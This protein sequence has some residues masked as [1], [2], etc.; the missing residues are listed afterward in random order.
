MDMVSCFIHKNPKFIVT[1]LIIFNLNY[2]GST[3]SQITGVWVI[4]S[5]IVGHCQDIFLWRDCGECPI[6]AKI[7]FCGGNFY[8]VLNIDDLHSKPI[9]LK[10]RCHHNIHMNTCRS[11]RNLDNT[12]DELN[13]RAPLQLN[14][15]KL[16]RFP[17]GEPPG[18]QDSAEQSLHEVSLAL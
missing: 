6:S 9:L 5:A 1:F 18:E 3:Q 17:Q 2:S 14:L 7:L 4:I 15:S 12:I 10:Y 13:P 16:N 8:L 11:C